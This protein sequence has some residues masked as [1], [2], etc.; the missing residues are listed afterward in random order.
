[1]EMK[2][3]SK[4]GEI[5]PFTSE[6]FVVRKEARSG[7]RGTCKDCVNEKGK[8]YYE[9]NKDK[10][11]ENAHVRYLNNTEKIL[12]QSREYYSKNKEQHAE[13]V[14]KYYDKNKEYLL[15]KSKE[16]YEKNKDRC[17]ELKKAWRCK[18]KESISLKSKEYYNQN[19]EKIAER[20][21]RYY[22]ENRDKII[23]KLRKYERERRKA[24]SG[25]RMIKSLRA[26]V[27]LAIKNNSKSDNT[28]ALIGCDIEYLKLHL[29]SQFKEGMTMDNYGLNG[30]EIDHIR[31]C[32]SFDLTDEQQ[33]RE[34]F[35]YTNL[36]PLWADENR[37]KSSIWGNEYYEMGGKR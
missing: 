3:C 10:I 20:R 31:P 25:F 28:K 6:Y 22:L 18:N 32:A 24:D 7:L 17:K 37:K 23:P 27:R 14:K 30:W 19:K 15:L 13:S 11:S 29:E 34:C 9:K 16:Y 2:K 33:Q 26:R 4:C 36:Q 35:H 12:K 8:K 1:M 21:A 5:K